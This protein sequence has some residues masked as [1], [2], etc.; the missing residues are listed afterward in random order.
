MIRVAI[1]DDY[2][3][4]IKHPMDLSTVRKKLKASKYSSLAEATADLMLI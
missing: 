1:V 4:I 2:P 3:M